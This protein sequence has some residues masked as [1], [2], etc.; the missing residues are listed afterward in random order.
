[1]RQALKLTDGVLPLYN[2]PDGCYVVSENGDTILHITA[3]HA[4]VPLFE[5]F[6]PEDKV[7]AAILDRI[8]VLEE[9]AVGHG[10]TYIIV[11]TES[12]DYYTMGLVCRKTA[13]EETVTP[14]DHTQLISS[15]LA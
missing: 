7:Q 5:I 12:P 2:N 11:R 6:G 13:I 1:M 4:F 3:K 9:Q 10:F 15:L 14:A 8:T